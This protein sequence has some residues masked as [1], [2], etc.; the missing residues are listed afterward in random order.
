[1]QI[2]GTKINKCREKASTGC[3]VAEGMHTSDD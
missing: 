2:K 3:P 1:L